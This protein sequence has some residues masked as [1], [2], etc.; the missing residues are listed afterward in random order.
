MMTDAAGVMMLTLR[1]F[2]P[3]VAQLEAV[4]EM[5]TAVLIAQDYLDSY[6]YG[7]NR[8]VRDLDRIVTRR[9]V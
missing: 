9:S 5:D 6:A 3:H 7:L 4:G 2:R 8:F 1:D